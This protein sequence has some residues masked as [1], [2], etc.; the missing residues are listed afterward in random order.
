MTKASRVSTELQP[1]LAT[2]AN[3]LHPQKGSRMATLHP[4]DG[5]VHKQVNYILSQDISNT[6]GW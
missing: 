3:P 2:I 4:P 6:K 1:P 5:S